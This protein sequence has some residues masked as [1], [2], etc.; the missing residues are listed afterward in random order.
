MDAVL[1]IVNEV[2]SRFVA[3]ERMRV[4]L[5]VQTSQSSEDLLLVPRVV[6][7]LLDALP[8]SDEPRFWWLTPDA[9][10]AIS[11]LREYGISAD[12]AFLGTS[13]VEVLV[14][15]QASDFIDRFYARESPAVLLTNSKA[16]PA[17]I[18]FGVAKVEVRMAP[19][20][21]H[22]P[23]KAG[24]VRSLVRDDHALTFPVLTGV[25][26]PF[27]GMLDAVR[28]YERF[29]RA[30]RVARPFPL[31]TSNMATRV[32]SSA[33]V[34]ANGCAERFEEILKERQV[35]PSLQELAYAAFDARTGFV[36]NRA[37]EVGTLSV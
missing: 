8:A 19:N 28:R 9:P 2:R 17:P 20:L 23:D 32:V 25:E 15:G 16:Y 24:C 33:I 13:E 4:P 34:R 11:E 30:D 35:L 14:S 5:Y 3:E 29:V 12:L 31:P 10:A 18:G 6:R 7:H 36:R 26:E 22:L 21:K 27:P 1:T 37:G